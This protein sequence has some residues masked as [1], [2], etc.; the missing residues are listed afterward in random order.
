MR[1]RNWDWGGRR[2]TV[3]HCVADA[4]RA[5]RRADAWE[6]AVKT[7]SWDRAFRC[8]DVSTIVDGRI[9]AVRFRRRNQPAAARL[10]S[11]ARCR[12]HDA[13]S[14]SATLLALGEVAAGLSQRVR[15]VHRSAAA[16]SDVRSAASM[17]PPRRR[18]ARPARP[19]RNGTYLVLR[20]LHQDVR[21]SGAISTLRRAATPSSA[22]RWRPPWSAG[23]MNGA[24][25]DARP[26]EPIAGIRR[27]PRRCRDNQFTYASDPDGLRCPLGA[28]IRRANPRTADLPGGAKAREPAA[29]HAGIQAGRRAHRPG[30]VDAF[31]PAAATRAQI[32]RRALRRRTRSAPAPATDRQGCISPAWSATSRASS[33]SC[34]TP[35]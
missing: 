13:S 22:T 20:D 25:A 28:H 35:G 1:P 9:R 14:S 33:N 30:R 7:Q 31:P 4:L 8:S 23:A 19:G 6:A 29:A 12:A 16:R 26:D 2:Q 5:A 15:A 3:P 10:A 17:L 24:A 32:R 11:R 34:R 18:R 27:R 21:G